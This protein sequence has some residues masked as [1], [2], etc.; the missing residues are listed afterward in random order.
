MVECFVCQKDFTKKEYKN[1]Y[2]I[3]DEFVCQKCG[4]EIENGA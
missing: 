2:L 1:G 3:M 4:L